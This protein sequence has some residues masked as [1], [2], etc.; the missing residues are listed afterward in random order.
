[1]MSHLVSNWA[2]IWK[3][4]NCNGNA[5][6][7]TKCKKHLHFCFWILSWVKYPVC[8]DLIWNARTKKKKLWKFLVWICICI[9]LKNISMTSLLTH[10]VAHSTRPSFRS[11]TNNQPLKK[12][13]SLVFSWVKV[14]KNWTSFY[15]IKWFKNWSFQ[16]MSIIFNVPL[17]WHSL[18]KVCFKKIRIIFAIFDNF[19]ST[20]GM[21]LKLFKGLVI[22]FG[23]KVRQG[24]VCNIVH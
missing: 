8:D 3:I 11:K 18:M 15:K 14:V 2:S 7:S 24:R 17:K 6:K 1:M 19:Y 10:T 21:T 20:D 9:M 5:M 22:G 13:L 12:F 16:K 23:P 4:Q